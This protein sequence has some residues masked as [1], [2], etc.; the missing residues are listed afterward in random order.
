MIV[1]CAH[2]RDGSRQ[3]EGPMSLE[4]A[5]A[6][7]T[8]GGF[9]WLGMFEPA[10]EEL[11]RVRASFGLHELAVE[12]A[13]AFHLRP[14]AEQYE[15]G[16]E[17]IV[18]RTARYD[19]EREEVD[20]GE[21]SVF[22]AEH[23]VITV[24]QGIAS[25]LGGARS[26]LE[27]RPELLRAGSASTLWAILDQVVDSYSPVVA[28]LERDIEQIEATV[29]SGTVAPTERIYFL[30]R[31]ATDFYRAV[32]P[33][34]AVL[35]RRVLPRR[36]PGELLPYFRDVQDHLL[37]V[38][39][40][41]A[42]QRDLLATVLEANIAVISVEQNKINLRQSATM[43]RLTIIATVF[44]PLSFVV[45]FFGQNFEWLVNHIS[46]LTAFITLSA[47]GLLLPVLVLYVWL[48]RRPGQAAQPSPGVAD[49]GD[50]PSKAPAGK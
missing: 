26:R 11:D 27:R 25:E 44:L 32:H 15:D 13:Q 47:V 4:E 10:P 18:L 42:A 20:T 6:R 34:L 41:V 1:D 43:E 12:D 31:E 50:H 28:E 39:E 23:F 40:E 38:N 21:I 30:R 14:K 36:S 16:T 3:H 19:D 29:F 48:R 37:L 46:S 24:R 17:L 33:L 35:A 22:L 8:E 9:V 2:Y 45:G 7:C 49:L 5:A